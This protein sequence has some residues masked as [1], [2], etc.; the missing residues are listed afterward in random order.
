M[1]NQSLQTAPFV[2]H[3]K[4]RVTVTHPFHPRLGEEIELLGYRRSFGNEC[5]DC[6]DREGRLTTVPLAWTDAA[7]IDDPFVVAS[8]GR[9]YF[10]VE[11]LLQLSKLIREL[12]PWRQRESGIV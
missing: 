12:S 3:L 10:R 6:R 11:D 5:L 9:S 4:Q 2:D 1:R 7:G 8:A